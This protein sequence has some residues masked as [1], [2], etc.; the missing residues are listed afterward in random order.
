MMKTTF[1]EAITED[2]L[3]LQGLLHKSEDSVGKAVLHIHGM[4]GNFYFNRFYNS[5]A[6]S[7]TDK[8]WGFL[9]V[10]TRGHDVASWTRVAGEKENYKMIGNAQ[11]R[12]E[13]CLIDI[14]CW[15][16]F[17]E[18]QGY[19][20]IILQGHSLGAVKVA[21]YQAKT[22]N[23]R[24][25]GL[26]LISP[27]DMIALAEAEKNR[28]EWLETARRMIKEGRGD[29]LM[30]GILWDYYLI[31]ANTYLDFSLRDDAV[32]V[33]NLYDRDKPSVLKDIKVPILAIYGEKDD[34]SVLPVK[35]S[36]EIISKKVTNS[37]KFDTA[38]I[39]GA[40]HSFFGHEE[41]LAEIIAKW[42]ER[43]RQ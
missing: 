36:L 2:K 43:E 9:T 37:P 13:D 20:D 6:K 38:I 3:L 17:L 34:A 22:K 28:G 30:P 35:E 42:L 33:F 21:Y 32:D 19:K 7:F 31:S 14:R 5:M 11:E 12:F 15:I 40:P 18:K 24:V 39:K 4:A 16:K 26:I 27:S 23:P 41:E 25:Q 8:G 29:E 1:T 10:N